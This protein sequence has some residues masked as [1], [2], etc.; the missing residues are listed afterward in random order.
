MKPTSV[1]YWSRF[2]IAIAT[3]VGSVIWLGQAVTG[4]LA[5]VI[6]PAVAIL[7]YVLTVEL[8]R[9]GLRY[10]EAQ[11]KT[12]NRV[13]TLGIGT[14]IFAWLASLIAAYTLLGLH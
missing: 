8:Y 12:K 13:I 3:G 10:G 2:F 4:A 1:V 6:Y 9:Y 14:Y 5:S 7:V 11:L